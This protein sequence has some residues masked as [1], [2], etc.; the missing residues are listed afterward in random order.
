MSRTPSCGIFKPAPDCHD[1]FWHPGGSASR[2]DLIIPHVASAGAATARPKS[3]GRAALVPHI[4]WD[5]RKRRLSRRCSR[6]PVFARVSVFIEHGPAHRYIERGRRERIYG[7]GIFR[8]RIAGIVTAFCTVVAGGNEISNAL[9]GCLLCKGT[10]L[11]KLSIRREVF[12]S[13]ETLRHDV[14]GIVFD[15]VQLREVDAMRSTPS[16]VFVPPE[17]TKSTVDSGRW[18][19]TKSRQAWPRLLL[20]HPGCPD[21]GRSPRH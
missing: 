2:R 4:F 20:R 8:G 14:G 16:V 10:D 7:N 5:V 17:T 15:D 11:L 3:A 9:G 18:R 19:W 12:A 13:A 6:G 1:R 21:Q